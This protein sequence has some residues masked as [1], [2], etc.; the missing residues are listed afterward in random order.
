LESLDVGV[1][2]ECIPVNYLNLRLSTPRARFLALE[3]A[4]QT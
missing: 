3:K 4:L 2:R 1:T